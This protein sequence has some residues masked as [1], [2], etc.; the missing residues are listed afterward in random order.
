MTKI[1]VRIVMT[2]LLILSLLSGCTNS[3]IVSC[4]RI[5][6]E[7]EVAYAYITTEPNTN[8]YGGILD[9]DRYIYYGEIENGEILDCKRYV[10]VV[11][12]HKSEK[13]YS[14]KEYCIE[15]RMYSDGHHFDE[16]VG[17][18]LYLTDTVL[19]TINTSNT[20]N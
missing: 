7:H 10:D 15:R 2:S 12:I 3:E 8:V 17:S 11:T 5:S 6:I 14:Y 1:A 4:E 9:Y 19:A 13:S 18:A 20:N 16:V